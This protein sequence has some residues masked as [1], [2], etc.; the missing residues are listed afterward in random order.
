MT[1]YLVEYIKSLTKDMRNAVLRVLNE[2]M[3][4]FE[5][6]YESIPVFMSEVDDAYDFGDINE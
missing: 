1:D 6:Y 2:N 5:D 3:D 4:G